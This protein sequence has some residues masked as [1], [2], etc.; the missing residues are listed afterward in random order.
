MIV[1]YV[2]LTKKQIRTNNKIQTEKNKTK[3][4]HSLFPCSS[5]YID[6]MFIFKYLF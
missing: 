5:L 3:P 4:E 6:T 2:E 1:F